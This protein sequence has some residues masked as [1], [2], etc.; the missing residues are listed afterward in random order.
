MRK[1]IYYIGQRIKERRKE[2]R[3]TQKD[4][5]QRI[6]TSY[7]YLSHI[8]NSVK[9]PSLEMLVCLSRELDVS[10]DYLISS[11]SDPTTNS[12]DSAEQ[13][14][15]LLSASSPEE[16]SFLIELITFIHKSINKHD[17]LSH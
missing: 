1:S 4:L 8:E 3:W 12:D 17:L 7:K 9:F 14:N 16:Y 11:D 15:I 13:I 10:L 6:G 5:A 2:K